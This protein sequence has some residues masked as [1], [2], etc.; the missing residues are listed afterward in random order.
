MHQM[1]TLN[2]LPAKLY[3]MVVGFMMTLFAYH[4]NPKDHPRFRLRSHDSH[5]Q[6]RRRRMEYFEIAYVRPSKFQNLG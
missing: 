1:N 6:Y 3:F 4:L 5:H 2:S